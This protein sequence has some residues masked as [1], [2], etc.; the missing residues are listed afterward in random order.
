MGLHSRWKFFMRVGQTLSLYG[1]LRTL[2]LAL[3]EIYF[4]IILQS[5]TGRIVRLDELNVDGSV[6]DHGHMYVPCPY[7]FIYQAFKKIS[8]YI[9][10]ATFIDYGCGLGR[11]LFIATRYP[12]RRII[13]IEASPNLSQEAVDNLTEFYARKS[14][15]TPEWEIVQHDATTYAV[16]ED[17]TVFFFNDPFDETVMNP[18]ISRICNSQDKAPRDIFAVYVNPGHPDIFIDHG[19]IKMETTVNKHNKG[20]IIYRR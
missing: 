2:P 12:F 17:A 16:P 20:F 9:Q 7:Y 18:V 19:F 5:K 3:A 13:G 4:E 6:S 10:G 8:V 15:K 14:L 11:V 1:I